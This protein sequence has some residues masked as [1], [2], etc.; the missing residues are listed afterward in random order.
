M[1]LFLATSLD[2]ELT[3]PVTKAT[4]LLEIPTEL[5][6]MIVNGLENH[7]DAFVSKDWNPRV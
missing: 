5:A 3:I 1:Y 2:R 6:K 7:Q 4:N